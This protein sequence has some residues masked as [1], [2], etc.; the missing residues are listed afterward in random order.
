MGAIVVS[1]RRRF[2]SV[3]WRVSHAAL[4]CSVLATNLAGCA[5]FDAKQRE[6]ALRPT[7]GRPA[8][9]AGLRAGD[10][11]FNV[12]VPAARPGAAAGATDQ[13]QLWWLPNA[14][15]RA[16]TLLYL[17]GTFRSLYQSNPRKMEALRSAGFSVV[18]VD[19][20]GWGESTPILPSEATIYADAQTAW[21]EL[22][23][24]QP[25]PR[26]RVLFGHSMGSAVAVELASHRHA[27]ADYGALVLEAA[28]NRLPDVAR[29][30]GVVGIVASWFA[31]LEF[32]SASKIGKVDAP[33][34]ML[35][36][37]VDRTVPVELGRRLHDAAPKGTRW[38]EFEGGSH[39]GLDL[40]SPKQYDDALRS[41]IAQLAR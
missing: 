29:S 8:D 35:H 12:T 1:F 20:R 13:L 36:G 10:E 22:V 23:R 26:K 40:E 24:R 39:S 15:P 2:L 16:P 18:A 11:I 17:H 27:G 21:A 30:A 28:F 19:Y 34:L 5:W 14:D 4:L 3:V 9:F 38:V 25:D 32:D 7:P 41:V 37:T 31:T 6:L 33:I